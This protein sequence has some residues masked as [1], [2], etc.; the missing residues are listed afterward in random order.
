M[1]ACARPRLCRALPRA[2]GTSGSAV[3]P[4]PWISPPARLAQLGREGGDVAEGGHLVVA[5][6]GIRDEPVGEL[7]R[8][9]AAPIRCPSRRSPRSAGR[10][11]RHRRRAR[12]RP[13]LRCRRSRR[14]RSPRRPTRAP[15]RRPGASAQRRCPGPCRDR[16]RPRWRAPPRPRA[17]AARPAS[18]VTAGVPTIST[19]PSA[20]KRRSGSRGLELVGHG[21]AQRRGSPLECR[22]HHVRRAARRGARVERRDV[23]VDRRE[24]DELR[25]DAEGLG[26][27]L[28]QHGGRALADLGGRRMDRKRPSE[29]SM[30]APARLGV[31]MPFISAHRPA[32]RRSPAQP[33]CRAADSRHSAMRKSCTTSPVA[34]RSPSRSTFC[35]R[36]CERISAEPLG[37]QVDALLGGPGRLRRRVAAE[38]AVARAVGVHAVGIDLDVV[39]AVG[40]DRG[41]AALGGDVRARCRRRRPCPIA[42]TRGAPRSARRAV[43]PRR[44]RERVGW[45]LSVRKSSSRESTSLT[46]APARRASAAAMASTR[47]NVLAPNEPP[48]GSETTRTSSSPRPERPGELAADVERRLRARPD[49]QAAVP[50]L[51]QA[52]VR[53]H[54]RV[55]GGRR[56]PF[57]LD[58]DLR[59][60]EARLAAAADQPRAVADVRAG[61]RA[62]PGPGARARRDLLDVVDDAAR[63]RRA[64]RP[65]R[66]P[67]E[68][69][70]RRA[71]PPARAARPGGD[72]APRRRPPDRRHSAPSPRAPACRGRGSRRARSPRRRLAS[73]ARSPPGARPGAPRR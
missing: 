47:V 57:A 67:P 45:R 30:R 21:L 56:R 22:R 10:R 17:P 33:I 35:S 20:V 41:P 1:C 49:R 61:E 66:S 42:T 18:V 59:L 6:V 39:E 53:L 9:V 3:S 24:A 15:P 37:Q 23:G 43:A 71:R 16:G 58:D 44:T 46:G 27:Q 55:L 54:R 38:G 64:R 14:R 2:G 4:S 5:H 36:S 48:I 63:R 40:A 68:D 25:I 51:G 13:R 73:A 12:R 29:S 52:G 50:P 8:L 19:P 65:G 70:P 34:K 60:V 11:A 31:C 32:P 69:R 62:H 7:D 72:P 28:R 26:R